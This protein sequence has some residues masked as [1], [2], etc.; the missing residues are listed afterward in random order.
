MKNIDLLFKKYLAANGGNKEAMWFIIKRFEKYIDYECG[1]NMD[2][3]NTIIVNLF[4]FS[5][6]LDKKFEEFCKEISK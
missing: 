1:G 4:N 5:E 6:G 2:L 3:K